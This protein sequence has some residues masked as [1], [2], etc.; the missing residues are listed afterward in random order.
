MPE[1]ACR[2]HWASV[3]AMAFILT[4]MKPFVTSEKEESHGCVFLKDHSSSCRR[5]DRRMTGIDHEEANAF[6]PGRRRQWLSL[7]E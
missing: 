5:V 6:F 7:Q 3:M 2:G 1:E 4:E